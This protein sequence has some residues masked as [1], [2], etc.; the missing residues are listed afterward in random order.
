M[1][2]EPSSSSSSSTATITNPAQATSPKELPTKLQT[3]V[4][5]LALDTSVTEESFLVPPT[6]AQERKLI[7]QKVPDNLNENKSKDGW[8]TNETIPDS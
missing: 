8:E 4:D 7:A 2:F 3:F 5:F 6:L 1:N